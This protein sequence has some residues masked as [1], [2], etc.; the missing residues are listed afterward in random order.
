MSVVLSSDVDVGH[1]SL[2]PLYMWS[3]LHL[4]LCQYHHYYCG[5][6][7]VCLYLHL[8][9]GARLHVHLCTVLMSLCSTS[10]GAL[11]DRSGSQFL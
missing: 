7:D 5:V 11:E 9:L 4:V 3:I 6:Y 8:L 2:T 1:S 10:V